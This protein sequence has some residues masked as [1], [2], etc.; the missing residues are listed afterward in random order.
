MTFNP[1]DVSLNSFDAKTG[2]SDFK[3]TGTINNLLGFLLSDKKLKGNFNLNSNKLLVS[4]FMVEDETATQESNKTTTDAESLKIPDFLDCTINAKANTVAYDNLI[5]KDVNGTLVINNQEADLKNLTSNL[6][7]GVLALTGKISTRTDTPTFDLN[8][9]ADGFD[10]SESFKSLDLLQ[11][12]APIANAIQ[13]KL[14]TVIK[15]QGTLG[16]DFTPNLTTVSGD[17]FAE[18]LSTTINEN[19]ASLISKLDG[20]LNFIDFSKINL[21]DLKAKLDFS[22]GRVNVKPF[23]IKYKDIN[24]VVS[25]GHG[26][27]KTLD[28]NAVFQVP[29]KY[30]GSEVNQLLGKINDNEVNKITVPDYC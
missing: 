10:I 14:N 21:N 13:G 1:T 27:D 3:A 9:G 19:N 17:A 25:G 2:T 8:I 22:N 28:Y 18:L 16:S 23:D 15:L 4:D 24:I 26:F 30:L 6:F 20:A 7:N 5:L 11:N 12:L 29:A